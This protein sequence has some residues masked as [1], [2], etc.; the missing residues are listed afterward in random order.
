MLEQFG[1]PE[2]ALAAVVAGRGTAVGAGTLATTRHDLAI[3]WAR[4]ARPDVT[5]ALFAAARHARLD[6]RRRRRA[7]PRGDPGAATRAVRR[8]VRARSAAR[9]RARRD[10]RDAHRDAERARRRTRDRRVPGGAGITVVSGLAL[11]I[12]GAAH[13]GALDG[14]R[15]HAIGVVATG[16]DVTYPRRHRALYAAVREHG[17]RRERAR[18]RHPTAR[19]AVPGTEPHHR[20]AL[21]TSCVVVEATATGGATITAKYANDYGRTVF[22]LPG[23]RRNRAAAGCNALIKD[24]AQILLDPERS[25]DRARSR[26]RRRTLAA[27]A[28][29]DLRCRRDR[30]AR[31][32]RRR[33]RDDRPAR[34]SHR[35][36]TGPAR[37][38][39]PALGAV[40]PHR[41]G[42][43]AVVAEVMTAVPVR[44]PWRRGLQ[45]VRQA[46]A[47]RRS[48]IAIVVVALVIVAL[49]VA[50]G[51]VSRDDRAP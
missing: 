17:P 21:P 47:H 7:D 12:D 37:R 42:P 43:R 45:P 2:A 11:G 51:R 3:V 24:G 27:G 33:T 39:A 49:L 9:R 29:S 13:E 41:A 28:R 18:V 34:G 4:A 10:R 6:R 19:D 44:L 35:D 36:V 20:R 16:L 15:T 1:G 14:R 50:V 5:A 40:R 31:G 8:R 32:A 26:A 38:R 48:D 30:H 25:P 46:R 22:A 23:S